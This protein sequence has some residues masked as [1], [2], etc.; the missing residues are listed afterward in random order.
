MRIGK[1]MKKTL[2]LLLACLTFASVCTSC[3]AQDKDD[4]T[5]SGTTPG[6]DTVLPV[7]GEKTDIGKIVKTNKV[8]TDNGATSYKVLLPQDASEDLKK[9]ASELTL[10]IVEATGAKLTTTTNYVAGERYFALGDTALSEKGDITCE[11]SELGLSGYKI[12]TVDDSICICAYTDSAVVY[13]VYEYL[14]RMLGFDYFCVDTY[15]IDKVSTLYLYDFDCVDVPDFETRIC[16]GGPITDKDVAGTVFQRMRQ[17]YYWESFVNKPGLGSWHNS[18]GMVPAKLY[19]KDHPEWY[20]D[21]FTWN[22][23][24]G[25]VDTR[26]S[27]LCY[28]AHGDKEEQEAMVETIAEILFGL[29][30]EYPDK[31]EINLNMEDNDSECKCDACVADYNKY[32]ARTASVIL[33]FNRLAPVLGEKLAAVND[34]RK[35]TY[36]ISF[37]AYH[38]YQEAPVQVT[39]DAKGNEVYSYAPEMVLNEHVIP[40]FA[41]VFINLTEPVNSES[42]TVQYETV[43]KWKQIAPGMHVWLYDIWFYKQGSILYYDS[44]EQLA[45]HF[46]EYAKVGA[47]WIYLEADPRAPTAFWH[48]RNYIVSKLQWNIDEDIQTLTDR[49]FKGVFGSESETLKRIYLEEKT[50]IARNCKE[51]GMMSAILCKDFVSNPKWWPKQ[52]LVNWYETLVESEQKLTAE[53]NATAAQW[54]RLEQIS[55]LFMLI[56]MHR[57]DYSETQV[58]A[59]KTTLRNLFDSFNIVR[60]SETLS[61]EDAFA[62]WH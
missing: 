24:T 61:V 49:F 29:L 23:E 11:Y 57:R 50:L 10:F 3:T 25:V 17:T 33:F 31:N 45:E 20:N 2:C 6:T 16:N 48:F 46:R 44:V 35:D 36:K 39:K 51:L 52:V 60:V 30:R 41:N 15:T 53:G 21:T 5:G 34:P 58:A 59:Y 37:Y 1:I 47:D 19:Y 9:A 38:Q 55:P 26:Y 4:S 56:E 8:V 28:S 18:M 40:L 14:E 7:V 42:N 22:A 62:S 27:Q 13:G 54:V 32:G 12:K 43:R